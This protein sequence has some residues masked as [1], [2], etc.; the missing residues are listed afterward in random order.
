MKFLIPTIQMKVLGSIFVDTEMK[1]VNLFSSL[2][3]VSLSLG[4]K[5]LKALTQVNAS[6]SSLMLRVA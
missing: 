3:T 5:G 1:S 4:E 6:L 2:H